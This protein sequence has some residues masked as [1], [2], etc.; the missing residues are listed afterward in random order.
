[1]H[2]GVRG[3]CY[4]DTRIS[5][6]NFI[7]IAAAPSQSQLQSKSRPAFTAIKQ[8]NDTGCLISFN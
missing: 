2:D 7:F 1:M 5:I 6:C 4:V 3:G 8:P